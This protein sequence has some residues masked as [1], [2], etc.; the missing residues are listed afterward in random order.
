[1]PVGVAAV[2]LHRELLAFYWALGADIVERQVRHGWG[3]G[4]HDPD[5]AFAPSGLPMLMWASHG[6]TISRPHDQYP[7]HCCRIKSGYGLAR[8]IEE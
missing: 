6:G 8:N 7:H 2:A 5:S 1:M 4:S 3:S